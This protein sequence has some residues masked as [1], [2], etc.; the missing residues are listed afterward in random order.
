MAFSADDLATI[1]AA[2][3]SGATLV[4]FGDGREVRYNTTGEL[5]AAREAI[6]QS[7]AAGSAV[8]PSRMT[9]VIYSDGRGRC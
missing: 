2:I 1:E 7:I 3:T 6:L 9:R 8:Q 5:I 4:R